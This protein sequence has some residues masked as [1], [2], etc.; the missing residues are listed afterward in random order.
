MTLQGDLMILTILN[1]TSF[2]RE[3]RFLSAKI[4]R[5]ECL[6]AAKQGGTPV[7]TGRGQSHRSTGVTSPALLIIQLRRF[8]S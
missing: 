2:Y 1:D 5:A 6:F 8:S 7:T 4:S 3:V